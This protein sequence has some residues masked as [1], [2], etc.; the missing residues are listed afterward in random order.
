MSEPPSPPKRRKADGLLT[1]RVAQVVGGDSEEDLEHFETNL[2][3]RS[4]QDNLSY[5]HAQSVLMCG[6]R[7]GRRDDTKHCI[8][9]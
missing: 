5:L 2:K 4:Y 7:S 3:F 9:D 8:Y 1:R 6:R